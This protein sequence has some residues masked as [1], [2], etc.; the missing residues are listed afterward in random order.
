MNECA[1]AAATGD[2]F[3]LSFHN[4]II[5]QKP[6]PTLILSLFP[7][8]DLL[9]LGFQQEWPEACIV[10]GPD[11]I[12]GS[13]H[14]IRN[15]HP[16]AKRF[17]G[18]IG[19]PPCQC[20]SRLRYLNPKCGEKHGNLIP[21]FERVV[22]EAQPGWFLMENVPD[23]PELSVPGYQI[24]SFVFNN[25]WTGAEQNRKRRISFGTADGRHLLIDVALFEAPL[26]E[27]AVT[28]SNRKVPVKLGGS[29]RIKCTYRP[30][31]I[32]GGHGAV[33]RQRD[34]GHEYNLE[35]M[36]ELQ[37]LPR[38]FTDEMPFT[39]HGKRQ[40]IGNG[41]AMPTGRAI[42]KAVRRAMAQRGQN[43]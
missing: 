12:F 8:I 20:F 32:L 7:G 33:P 40:A 24:H 11:V 27:L 10:R 5:P 36:C 28:S 39:K 29:G 21:E 13:L 43:E 16:P 2:E 9:G 41:V 18:V 6:S 22:S 17:D 42:A 1:A 4:A 30:P 19:G 38:G 35:R 26:V 14:D 34:N 31:T 25:R 23:V 37:G 3:D 15:F